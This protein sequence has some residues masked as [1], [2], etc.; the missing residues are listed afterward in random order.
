ML[1]EVLAAQETKCFEV[2]VLQEPL[3]C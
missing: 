3:W 1:Y 2:I